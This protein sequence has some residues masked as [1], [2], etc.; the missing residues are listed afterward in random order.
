MGQRQ[1]CGYE[2]PDFCLLPK[3]ILKAVKDLQNQLPPYATV[4]LCVSTVRG[5]SYDPTQYG[6][7]HFS[8]DRGLVDTTYII[9]NQ[10]Y[11]IRIMGHLPKGTRERLMGYNKSKQKTILTPEQSMAKAKD[12]LTKYPWLVE[13]EH[14]DVKPSDEY[15]SGQL[16]STL[17]SSE[18]EK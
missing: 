9:G 8:D 2:G 1:T 18:S 6:R 4:N 3:K 11:C 15:D 16:N 17:F 13:G 10:L 7:I 14:K 5:V 12:Q